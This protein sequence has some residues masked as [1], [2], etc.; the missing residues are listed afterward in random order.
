MRGALAMAAVLV[1]AAGCSSGNLT[2]QSAGST[3]ITPGQAAKVDLTTEPGTQLSFQVQDDF[4]GEISPP[5]A[6]I[7]ADGSGHASFTWPAP[8]QLSTTT[9]H[10][11]TTAKNADRTSSKDIH[12]VVGGN[13]RSC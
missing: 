12:A 2:I 6:P 5:V 1:G 9:V 10:F 13:G 7:T 8:G 11:I 4:G 3:C